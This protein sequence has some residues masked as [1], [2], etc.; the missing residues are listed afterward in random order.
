V[1]EKKGGVRAKLAPFTLVNQST[2]IAQKQNALPKLM[3]L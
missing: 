3:M 1:L 2:V